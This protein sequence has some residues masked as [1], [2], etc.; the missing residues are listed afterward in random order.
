MAS[1][2]V[3]RISYHLPFPFENL[4]RSLFFI[5]VLRLV[6]VIETI[7]KN[8]LYSFAF[9]L[10]VGIKAAKLSPQFEKGPRLVKDNASKL[11][12]STAAIKL[13][14]TCIFKF[15]Y[16]NSPSSL[17]KELQLTPDN[18][19]LPLTRRNFC[20]PSYHFCTI[21]TEIDGTLGLIGS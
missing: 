17:E 8:D 21:S 15:Q 2:P 20:F 1:L 11:L 7:L 18:S 5:V 19:N 10:S 4:L 13:K 6:G 16:M 3:I 14:E 9:L 12:L